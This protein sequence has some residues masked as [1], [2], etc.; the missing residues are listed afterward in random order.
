MTSV[1]LK[2]KKTTAASL[3]L[4]LIVF[5]L[6]IRY[7]TFWLSHTAGDQVQYAGLAMKLEKFG[8]SGYTLRGIDIY[9]IDEQ[10]QVIAL[11]PSKDRD[12][13]LLTGLKR[14]GAGYYDI[15]FFHKAPAFPV[16]ILLSKHIFRPKG[17]YLLVR[18]HLGPKVFTEKPRIFFDSQFYA[19]IVPFLF[20]LG[21]VLLTFFLGSKLFSERIG[22]YAAFILAANPV[23]ILTSCKLWADDMLAFFVALSV[24]LY[25]ISLGR[26]RAWISFLAGLSCGMAVLTKQ[27]GGLIFPAIILYTVWLKREFLRDIKKWPRLVFDKDL[28]CYALGLAITAGPWF[29]K[30]FTVYG[31]PLYLPPKPDIV[32]TDT[33]GWFRTLKMRPPAWKLFLVGIPI[34]SPAF[35]FICGALKR[36]LSS[37]WSPFQRPQKNSDQIIL[38]W[39]WILAFV[40]YFVFVGGGKEHRRM[41]PV[42]PAIALLASYGL[43]M[44][45][46]YIERLSGKKMFAEAMILFILAGSA[47]WSIRIGLSTVIVNGALILVPF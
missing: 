10:K 37:V 27:N 23:G 26:N 33:T 28:I 1:F 42:Y 44:F 9:Y 11:L 19:V 43:N 16:A 20:S 5:H 46:M 7:N 35:V 8:L 40:F 18:E 32:R 24:L 38:L 41:L 30:I 25:L 3:L 14:S 12:G 4:V 39:F 6:A 36:F 17:D 31:E 15:P 22:F 13:S 34:I 21:L 45:R 29:Y 2:N 47:F